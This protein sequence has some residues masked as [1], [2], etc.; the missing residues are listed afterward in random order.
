[1]MKL[2]ITLVFFSDLEPWSATSVERDKPL[3]KQHAPTMTSCAGRSRR[4]REEE[5]LAVT[6]Q[7]HEYGSAASSVGNAAAL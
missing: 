5:S 6:L 4:G 3:P 7:D 2:T 1:M